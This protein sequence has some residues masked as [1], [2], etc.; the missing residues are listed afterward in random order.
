MSGRQIR[1]A[2]AKAGIPAAAVEE[3]KT[4]EV[5]IAG[6]RLAKKAARV[7]GWGGYRTGWGSWTLSADHRADPYA[8]TQAGREHY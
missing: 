7:L 5:T 2:L 8:G 3:A 6:D 1:A 4:G